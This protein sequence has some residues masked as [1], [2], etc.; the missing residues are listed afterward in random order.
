MD[1]NFLFQKLYSKYQSKAKAKVAFFLLNLIL[2]LSELPLLGW[3]NKVFAKLISAN[4]FFF[5]VFK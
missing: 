4:L 2:K 5:D 3:I 1:N